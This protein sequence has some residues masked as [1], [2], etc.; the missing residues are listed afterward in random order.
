MDLWNQNREQKSE[1]IYLHIDHDV[2]RSLRLSFMRF[3]RW[4]RSQYTFPVKINVYIKNVAFIV[5][6]TTGESGTA[7][8]FLPYRLDESPYIKIAAG[9]FFTLVQEADYFS[10]T[11][12]ELCSLAHEI[13]H[14]FQWQ[15][16]YD[17]DA[18]LRKRE[19]ERQANRKAKQ[20]VRKYIEEEHEC[21]VTGQIYK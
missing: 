7:N 18:S 3:A 9:D 10:A 4:I 19:R 21:W 13:T 2:P 5:S 15:N 14:Y 12:A 11:C 8:I 20:I 16:G 1:G 6:K 17:M